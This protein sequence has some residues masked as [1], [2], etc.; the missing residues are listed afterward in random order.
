M[1]GPGK[2]RMGRWRE[3]IYENYFRG[4]PKRCTDLN[5]TQSVRMQYCEQ[6]ESQTESEEKVSMADPIGTIKNISELIKK[7]NDLELMKQIVSLQTEVFD[8]QTENL[9]LKKEIAGLNERVKMNR[10]ERTVIISKKVRKCRTARGV[11][12]TTENQLRFLPLRN[13]A[14]I[15]VVAV[16]C[17]ISFI[18]RDASMTQVEGD[19]WEGRGLRCLQRLG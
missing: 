12:K 17:A 13:M 9:A 11:G 6:S 3:P 7:Y 10:R 1:M 15:L 4:I 8:L 19:K 2:G 14:L 18:L 5:L 16:A